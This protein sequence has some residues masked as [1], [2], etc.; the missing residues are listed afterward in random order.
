MHFLSSFSSRQ[1]PTETDNNYCYVCI[2]P[3]RSLVRPVL[4]PFILEQDMHRN[5]PYA[6]RQAAQMLPQQNSLSNCIRRQTIFFARTMKPK[7]G[8]N[9]SDKRKLQLG[10]SSNTYVL[11]YLKIPTTKEFYGAVKRNV[12]FFLLPSSPI[13]RPEAHGL[14][15]TRV[16]VLQITSLSHAR[17]TLAN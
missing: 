7:Q 10:I 11:G 1:H 14:N 13:H 4:C 6:S 2:S 17:H 5:T 16:R 3:S 9:A 8:N 12:V 15:Q